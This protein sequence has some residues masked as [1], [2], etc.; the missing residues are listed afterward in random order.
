MAKI[1]KPKTT[2]IKRIQPTVKT[3]TSLARQMQITVEKTAITNLQHIRRKSEACLV[4]VSGAD[5]CRRWNLTKQEIMIGRSEKC[6]IRIDTEGVSRVHATLRQAPVGIIIE[7]NNSTNGT[8]VN[9]HPVKDR[10]LSDGDQIR[11]G[12]A[13]L[14]FLERDN[15]ESA[16]YDELYRLTTTDEL[17]QVHNRRYFFSMI[18]QELARA[19]RKK[20]NLSVIMFDID[21]FKLLND[22]YGHPAGDVVLNG[23]A[24]RAKS[25]CRQEDV[26]ARYGGEEF[27]LLLPEIGLRK[28]EKVAERI[29]DAIAAT[30]FVYHKTLISTSISAGVSDLS[31]LWL[32]DGI[33]QQTISQLSHHLIRIADNK[34]YKAKESG[35]NCVVW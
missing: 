4:T 14:K 26:I 6:T 11:L 3:T 7:D 25:I 16:Y 1:N 18:E 5:A 21:H 20:R 32:L 24:Q 19:F 9:G 27:T 29:R 15:I 33:N 17:T 28:A 10:L 34:L 13:V 12:T 2:P 30:P 8:L 31:E 35:R 22:T 23:V